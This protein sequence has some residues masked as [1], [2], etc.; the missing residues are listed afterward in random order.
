MIAI[1][2]PLAPLPNPLDAHPFVT[3]CVP[4]SGLPHALP[5]TIPHPPSSRY[6]EDAPWEEEGLI[7]AF[8]TAQEERS[9]DEESDEGKEIIGM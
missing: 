9:H 1:S 6:C 4:A 2:V 7:S 5:L 3:L 8:V